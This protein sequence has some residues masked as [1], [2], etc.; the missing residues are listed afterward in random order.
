MVEEDA[1]TAHAIRIHDD[2]KIQSD[3]FNTRKCRKKNRT[4]ATVAQ[5]NSASKPS[6]ARTK[7]ARKKMERKLRISEQY[8]SM[9][10]DDNFL[11][12]DK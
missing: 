9:R 10:K 8:F 5:P 4:E 3:G 12:H 6:D 11:L 7:A 1:H 2:N